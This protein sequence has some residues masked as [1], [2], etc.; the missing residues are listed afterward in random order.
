MVVYVMCAG[1]RFLHGKSAQ[2]TGIRPRSTLPFVL[3]HLVLADGE[4]AEY[5]FELHAAGFKMRFLGTVF[6]FGTT[7][8]AGFLA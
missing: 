1:T 3:V 7:Y 2:L 4:T 5:A 6:N 8:A